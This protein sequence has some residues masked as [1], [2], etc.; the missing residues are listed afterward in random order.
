MRTRRLMP[1]EDSNRKILPRRS[2]INS[3]NPMAIF[4][5]RTIIYFPVDGCGPKLHITIEQNATLNS[6]I[7]LPNLIISLALNS[8]NANY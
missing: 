6:D 5:P 2:W 4:Q 3:H 1:Y 8:K 7:F